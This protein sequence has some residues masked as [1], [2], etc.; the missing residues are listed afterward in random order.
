VKVS[1]PKGWAAPSPRFAIAA[2]VVR[3]GRYIGQIAEAV[4]DLRTHAAF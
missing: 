4:V 1:V 2:D 3:D